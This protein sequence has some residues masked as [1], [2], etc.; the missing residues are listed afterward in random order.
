MMTRDGEN[1][2]YQVL[3]DCCKARLISD[4]QGWDQPCPYCGERYPTV[5]SH[6]EVPQS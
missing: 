4:H 1:V 3:L 6:T 2:E 5:I